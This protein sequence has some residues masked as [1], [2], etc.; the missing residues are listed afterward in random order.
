MIDYILR[1]ISIS[2]PSVPP[3][4]LRAQYT[5][6]PTSLLLKWV[7]LPLLERNGLITGYQLKW[8]SRCHLLFLQNATINQNDCTRVLNRNVSD[9]KVKFI[10]SPILQDTLTQLS[11]YTNYTI[12]IAAV[13]SAGVGPGREIIAVTDEG[14][15]V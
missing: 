6:M 8:I 13:T 10:R 7:E 11:P 14:G 1:V 3:G 4:H 5:L 2:A 12:R 9:F 15:N